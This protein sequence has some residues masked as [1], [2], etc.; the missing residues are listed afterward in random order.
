MTARD[1]LGIVEKDPNS[2]YGIWFPDLPGCFPAADE[3]DDLP[4]VAAEVLRLH[5][6]APESN[7]RAVPI[8]RSTADVMN[9]RH[10]RKSV[11]AGAS[12][13]LVHC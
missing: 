1:Y 10:V 2:A 12:T 11:R 6:E 7:G 9:D 5:I 4:R 13:L 3:F 8:P